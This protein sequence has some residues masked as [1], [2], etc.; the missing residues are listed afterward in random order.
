MMLHPTKTYQAVKQQYSEPQ[1]QRAMINAML[2]LF[3]YA[4]PR[5]QKK[6]KE[7]HEAWKS[8]FKSVDQITT[9]R[10]L[11][12][13]PSQHQKDAFM[14]L[15]DIIAKRDQLVKTLPEYLLLSLYTEIPPL[16][17]DFGN[18]RILS[19]D[20][21]GPEASNGNYVVVKDTFIRMVLNEFK[22]KSKRCLQYSKVLPRKLEGIIRE[23][24]KKQPRSHLIVSPRT[25]QAFT[26]HAYVVHVN[27]MLHR[28][29]GRP[30]TI[31]M[32][33]HIYITA[34]HTTTLT[35][36]QK[37]KLSQDMTHS[38]KM[39]DTYRLIF[40]DKKHG[41]CSCECDGLST[42]LLSLQQ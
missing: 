23:S 19:K 27:R 30:V 15:D 2:A 40:E 36:G 4:S 35:T 3:K 38:L 41:K 22:S 31:S 13:K 11:D 42:P 14:P 33:R 21:R 10:Y 16:R 12:N 17:A 20:P 39:A 32:L 37:L 28:V 1:S 9:Q 5:Y 34:K 7:A 18:M 29:L 26:D 24:L 6:H 25:G 8:L